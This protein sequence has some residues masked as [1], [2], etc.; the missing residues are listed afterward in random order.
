MK[1][2]LISIRSWFKRL[3]FRFRH[4]EGWAEKFAK[5]VL[6]SV[7][8]V[9][10]IETTRAYKIFVGNMAKIERSRISERKK[11]NRIKDEKRILRLY[12]FAYRHPDRETRLEHE[13]IRRH[14]IGLQGCPPDPSIFATS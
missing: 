7:N 11:I 4:K 14:Y 12:G 13:E 2:L 5:E 10:S 1:K 6:S 9:A 3:F 8:G